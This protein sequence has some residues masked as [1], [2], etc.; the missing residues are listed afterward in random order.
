MLGSETVLRGI[1]I[2]TAVAN[3]HLVGAQFEFAKDQRTDRHFP[4]FISEHH[5]SGKAT[6][7]TIPSGHLRPLGYQSKAKSPARVYKSFNVTEFASKHFKKTPQTPAVYRK[8]IN[9]SDVNTITDDVMKKRFGSIRIPVYNV[10]DSPL[11]YKPMRKKLSKLLEKFHY[12]DWFM[13]ATCPD[14]MRTLFKIPAF[15]TCAKSTINSTA[16]PP[17][18]QEVRLWLS[19][20]ET[21]APLQYIPDHQFLCLLSG[22]W[23]VIFME[24][25]H[26]SKVAMK[27]PVYTVKRGYTE[28]NID[29]INV[30]TY[31]EVKDVP[32]TWT[33]MRPGDCAFIPA[34]HLYHLR[35]FG[36]QWESTHSLIR[37]QTLAGLRANC[38]ATTSLEKLR[39]V[40]TYTEERR[41]PVLDASDMATHC[42]R[43]TAHQ[44]VLVLDTISKGYIGK[45][46]AETLSEGAL[47]FLALLLHASR[48]KRTHKHEEL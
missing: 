5:T 24:N 7:N 31:K 40:W 38:N 29:M 39:T 45:G 26:K 17:V 10:H 13:D 23:D 44:V 3:W 48:P 33:T 27:E 36:E 28:M 34:G 6:R 12:E 20:G 2:L 43:L 41:W 11:R 25:S 15:L 42:A 47:K 19:S 16:A 35:A 8:L 46:E 14:H 32:W 30:F 21:A 18:I 22:R 9:V 1:V 4:P 37:L